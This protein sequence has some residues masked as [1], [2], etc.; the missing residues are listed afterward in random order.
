MEDDGEL[1]QHSSIWRVRMIPTVTLNALLFAGIH[2]VEDLRR[3]EP[4][5]LLRIPVIGKETVQKIQDILRRI[6]A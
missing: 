2:T 6:G 3:C 4:E 1:T 5:D